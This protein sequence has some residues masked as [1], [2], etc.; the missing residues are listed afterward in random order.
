MIE[1]RL[2]I[3]GYLASNLSRL[4]RAREGRQF[5][6]AVGYWARN[7]QYL[8]LWHI[9]SSKTSGLARMFFGSPRFQA[10]AHRSPG[11]FRRTVVFKNP[12]EKLTERI[13]Y[14][15]NSDRLAV[16]WFLLVGR[17]GYMWFLRREGHQEWGLVVA[18]LHCQKSPL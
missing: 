4:R 18:P 9:S 12:I 13:R 14:V 15:L 7:D 3:C 6:K 10:L 5:G 16:G 8:I 11:F 2:P 1:R 17:S